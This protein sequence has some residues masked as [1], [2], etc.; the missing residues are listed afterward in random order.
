MAYNVS[1]NLE[2]IYL[3][4]ALFEMKQPYRNEWIILAIQQHFFSGG[5]VSFANEFKH[6]FPTSKDRNGVTVREVPVAMVALVAT[7]VHATLHE[8]RSGERRA[9]KFSANTFLDPYHGHV[10]SFN[11]I[12]E[13]CNHTFHAIMADI[14]SR[15]SGDIKI[16]TPN[17]SIVNLD[18]DALED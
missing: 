11:H 1:L 18:L 14:Y 10:G 12:Q 4:L 9:V 16:D 6:I 2:A 17:V 8:W 3:L 5:S 15:A 13:E 7:A